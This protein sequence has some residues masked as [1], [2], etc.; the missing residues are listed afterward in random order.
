MRADDRRDARV[1]LRTLARGIAIDAC[2]SCVDA[3]DG[4]ALAAQQL[5]REA[6]ELDAQVGAVN[7]IRRKP[8]QPRQ[9]LRN[10]AAPRGGERAARPQRVR[11]FASGT[12]ARFLD[13]LLQ[14]ALQIRGKF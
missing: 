10:L 3:A 13:R 12:L 9:L 4:A 2:E 7:V 5:L 6:H 8:G 11:A 1:E 14:I